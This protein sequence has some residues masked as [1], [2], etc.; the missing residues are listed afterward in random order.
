MHL[1]YFII[2]NNPPQQT[3]ESEI[4][5]ESKASNYIFFKTS[6]Y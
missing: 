1:H 3:I 5:P 6:D 2:G 4:P